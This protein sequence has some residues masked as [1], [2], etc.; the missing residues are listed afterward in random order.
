ML[1]FTS[2]VGT[3]KTQTCSGSGVHPVSHIFHTQ[4]RHRSQEMTVALFCGHGSPSWG[5][6][7]H[8]RHHDVII[9]SKL[10]CKSSKPCW[11][12]ET[13]PASCPSRVLDCRCSRCSRTKSKSQRLAAAS[14]D[15]PYVDSWSQWSHDTI[16]PDDHPEHAMVTNPRCCDWWQAQDLPTTRNA[17]KHLSRSK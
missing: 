16:H 13:N 1:S 11:S 12:W 2:E 15:N 8:H 3:H 4:A 7:N 10:H 5:K 6:D 14:S 9:T 17:A